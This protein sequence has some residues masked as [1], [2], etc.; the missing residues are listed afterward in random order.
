MLVWDSLKLTDFNDVLFQ[1]Q[2]PL[3]LYD[4]DEKRTQDMIKLLKDLTEKYVPK[5]EGEIVAEVFLEVIFFIYTS[6][7]VI[8][9][10][11]HE[12][13]DLRSLPALWANSR[14]TKLSIN[15][16]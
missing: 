4:C 6:L 8:V 16:G 2:F 11:A 1:L 10:H 9:L 5:I 7:H 3:G 13:C 15:F 14:L 12:Y